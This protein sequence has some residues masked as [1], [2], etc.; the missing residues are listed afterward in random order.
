[1]TLPPSLFVSHGAPNLVLDDI[2]ATDFLRSYGAELGAP[3]AAVVVSAHFE[4][5]K[6]M[7]SA[8]TAPN[9]IYDFSGFEPELYEMQY[10]APGH[11]GLAQQMVGLLAESGLDGGLAHDRGF[12]HGTWV[13]MM[14]L[15]PR[16]DVPVVQL[17]VSPRAGARHHYRIGEA[18][19][20][21]GEDNVLVLGSG[22]LTH[23]LSAFFR[24][25]FQKDATPPDWVED[26]AGWMHGK[27]ADG[28]IDRL[29]DYRDTAPFAKENHPT[30]EHLLPFFVA[31]GASRSGGTKGERIHASN[32]FG[33]L[34][35]DAYAFH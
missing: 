6:P 9:M 29:L 33:V 23:N 2:P 30:E 22:S 8:D 10:P 5:D 11:P 31:A 7:V 14:L 15:F 19:R 28:D 16:A 12:D 34:A 27:V 18:L 25:G 3:R 13:P 35:M 24:G 17:S 32:T 20:P 21:L 4:A 26:F 1:M